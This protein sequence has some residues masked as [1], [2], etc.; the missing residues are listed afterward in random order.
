MQDRI[1]SDINAA[2]KRG[3]KA[4]AE[5]LRLL[6]SALMNAKIAAG[7]DLNDAEAEKV[8]R[9]EMKSRVEARDLFAAND[10]SEQ[11]AK[12]EFERSVYAAYVPE[13]LSEFDIDALV[14]TAAK[15]AGDGAG[16]SQIMPAVMKAA[17]GKADGKLVAD[18]VKAFLEGNA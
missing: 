11:A 4:T 9:K 10:R 15:T 14:A 8:I 17:A 5:A 6:K 2:L 1:G 18:R 3:D 7:H 16:F 13:Q 12:E